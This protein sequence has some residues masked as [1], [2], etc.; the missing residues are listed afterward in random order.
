MT[1]IPAVAD[2]ARMIDHSL[3]H[4]TMT[5]RDLSEGC[6]IARAWACAPG[7]TPMS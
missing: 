4:P 7:S 2:L 3:L 5:D 1:S 6:A